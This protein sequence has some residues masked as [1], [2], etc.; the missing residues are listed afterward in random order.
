MYRTDENGQYYYGN[1][2]MLVYYTRGC[3]IS[4]LNP[5]A[6]TISNNGESFRNPYEPDMISENYPGP[7]GVT[8]ALWDGEKVR[9]GY[10][11]VNLNAGDTF[12]R[13]QALDMAVGR[14]LIQ[15]L[16]PPFDDKSVPHTVK[17]ELQRI[18]GRAKNYFKFLTS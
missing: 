7:I 13:K 12:N 10:S 3:K 11:R 18:Y 5:K 1:F 8:V 14:A 16:E 9:Y 17:P 6:Y 4:R 2:R 15:H